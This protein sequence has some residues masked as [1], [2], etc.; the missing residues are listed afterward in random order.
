V[1]ARH[2]TDGVDAAADEIAVAA[3]ELLVPEE[4]LREWLGEFDYAPPEDATIYVEKPI[5]GVFGDAGIVIAGTPDLVVVSPDMIEVVD[6]KSGDP[7]YA[8]EE[9]WFQLET[10]ALMAIQSYP[11]TIPT[12]R[13]TLHYARLG[14]NGWAYRD[15]NPFEA[16]E[17]VASVIEAALLEEDSQPGERAYRTGSHC[18]FCPGRIRCPARTTELKAFSALMETPLAGLVT[19]RNAGPLW[20]RAGQVE[21]LAKGVRESVKAFVELAGGYVDLGDGTA[22][23]QSTQHRK[24]YVVKASESLVT[25]R[26]KVK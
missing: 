9:A 15:I 14:E 8:E 2:L 7:D 25:R 11:V 18:S 6:W 20:E 17:R 16:L 13:T 3:R 22:L 1:A 10:Y 19:E 5:Q 26:V 23:K 4:P 24:G 21:K 12:V